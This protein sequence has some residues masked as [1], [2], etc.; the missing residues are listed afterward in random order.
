MVK[1]PKSGVAHQFLFER[2]PTRGEPDVTLAQIVASLGLKPLSARAERDI[3]DR[4]GFAL[5]KWETPRATFDL[6]DVISSLN[7]HAKALEK[8]SPV[9]VL[10]KRR[11]FERQTPRERYGSDLPM[12]PKPEGG[13]D[14]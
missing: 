9:A 5:A 1:L 2:D 4:L 10:A 8:F 11:A 14:T 13:S 6:A 3:R 12:G 7:A